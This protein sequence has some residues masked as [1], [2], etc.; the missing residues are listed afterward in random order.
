[1]KYNL[2]FLS[3]IFL[4]NLI[5]SQDFEVSPVDIKFNA[6]P[7][8]IQVRKVTIRNYGNTKQQFSINLHDYD[9]DDNGKKVVVK[10]GESKHTLSGWLNVN[11]SFFDLNPNESKEIDVI[12]TVPHDGTGTRWGKLGV[13][14]AVEQTASE[15]DKSLAAGVLVV[16][17]IVIW[18]TQTPKNSSNYNAL[19][20][21]LVDITLPKDTVRKFSATVVNNGDNIIKAKIFL[22]VADLSTANE[23]KYPPIEENVYPGSSKNVIL[24]VPEK[25]NAGRYVI[26]AI[27]DYGHRKP[28]EG[29]QIMIEQK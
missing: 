28:L 8:E 24:K 27:L 11:P 22:A 20:K 7:G 4:N 17:R 5:F 12:L 25:L 3:L 21:D 19:I 10:D 6:N 14:P 2:L 29:T 18:V 23:K 1:M 9:V 13:Q 26:A 15:A 16:P